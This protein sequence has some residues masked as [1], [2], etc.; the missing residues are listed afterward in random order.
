[1]TFQVGQKVCLLEYGNNLS[2]MPVTI[3]RIGKRWA[4]I[5]PDGFMMPSHRIDVNILNGGSW[6]RNDGACF[7]FK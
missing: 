6:L 2:S 7:I 4:E 1:M 5:T 3:T